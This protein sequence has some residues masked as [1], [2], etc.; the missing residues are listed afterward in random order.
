MLLAVATL[1]APMRRILLPESTY[2]AT[3]GRCLDGS[4]ALY[5]YGEA[6]NKSSTTWVIEL[7]GGGECHTQADC[8]NRAKTKLGYTS[9]E[10]LLTFHWLYSMQEARAGALVFDMPAPQALTQAGKA[11]M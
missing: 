5:Y 3:G 1:A 10:E 2:G 6:V 11:S 8:A 9:N 7:E 4:M